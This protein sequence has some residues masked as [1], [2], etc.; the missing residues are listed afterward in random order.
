MI[1]YLLAS[2]F[3]F[4]ELDT[5]S[6]IIGLCFAN[7]LSPISGRYGF[8]CGVLAGMFH[9]FVVVSVPLLHG[10]L[11]LYNGGFACAIV[12]MLLTPIF[13]TFFRTSGVIRIPGILPIPKRK[14]D[15]S[16]VIILPRN[17]RRRHIQ[18]VTKIE[19]AD[20]PDELDMD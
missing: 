17:H 13:E 1:G 9:S 15:N 14:D 3:G 11:C 10:G 2:L 19:D 5:Q 4:W 8:L 18:P 6:I 20:I 7:G 12:A 16:D